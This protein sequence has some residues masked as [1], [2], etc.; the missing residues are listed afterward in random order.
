MKPNPS[1]ILKSITE[2]PEWGMGDDW[3][4]S[5]LSESDSLST[6]GIDK[7]GN[8]FYMIPAQSILHSG[9]RFPLNTF[10][11][12]VLAEFGIAS[13]QLSANTSRIMIALYIGCHAMRNVECLEV[14]PFLRCYFIQTTRS[15]GQS[16]FCP[17][18]GCPLV[19]NVKEM[20]RIKTCS[21]K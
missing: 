17:L 4:F 3:A 16:Y 12:N 2:V 9:L 13:C 7:K 10:F 11:R 19:D 18:D 20:P 6:K 5:I 8:K 14:A 21:S 1:L 15:S